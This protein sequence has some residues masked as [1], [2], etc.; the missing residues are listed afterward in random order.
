[1]SEDRRVKVAVLTDIGRAAQAT[2]GLVATDYLESTFAGVAPEDRGQE[3]L[4]CTVESQKPW[5]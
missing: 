3:E 1:V 4:R 5:R 2:L